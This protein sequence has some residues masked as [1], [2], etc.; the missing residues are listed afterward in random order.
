M[1][2]SHREINY[3]DA[4]RQIKNHTLAGYLVLRVLKMALTLGKKLKIKA[5]FGTCKSNERT[6]YLTTKLLKT[7][8]VNVLESNQVRKSS[9]EIAKVV[10]DS[11]EGQ[12]FLL[13][14]GA[15]K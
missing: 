13:Q 3:F 5:I 2:L 8:T 11:G 1:A 7:V 12:H 9:Y 4:Y 15:R 6:S 10:K 14:A